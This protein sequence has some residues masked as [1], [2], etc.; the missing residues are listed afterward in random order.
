MSNVIHQYYVDD[1]LTQA[2]RFVTE[3]EDLSGAGWKTGDVKAVFDATEYLLNGWLL[4][5]GA[6]VSRVTYKKLWEF[7][8]DANLVRDTEVIADPN[9]FEGLCFGPG[10]GSTTF[11]IPNMDGRVLLGNSG[12]G[13]GKYV[14]EQLPN[15]TGY[16]YYDDP[17][18]GFAANYSSGALFKYG[19]GHTTWFNTADVHLGASYYNGY[20]LNAS[21][22]NAVYVDASAVRQAASA[23]NYV[24]KS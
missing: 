16:S 17:P 15:I 22:S 9:T 18:G 24:I 11:S 8:N 23:M 10:D 3:Q 21:F 7:A 13:V 6:T 14:K 19:T 2:D 12:T 20:G 1:D 4:M 5:N